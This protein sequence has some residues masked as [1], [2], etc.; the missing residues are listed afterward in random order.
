[1]ITVNQRSI[2]KT[3]DDI[4]EI[5]ARFN[6]DKDV[7]LSSGLKN[8]I[9]GKSATQIKAALLA[10]S[11]KNLRQSKNEEEIQINRIRQSRGLS[12]SRIIK[13]TTHIELIDDR[14]LD[15]LDKSMSSS[16]YGVKKQLQSFN[17]R[18][19]DL[20]HNSRWRKSLF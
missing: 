7:Q 8:A 6:A 11:N 14:M 17:Q 18:S 20:Y 9:R 1:M 3:M 16:L 4:E 15:E 2:T 10:E 12:E 5:K 13:R 19:E